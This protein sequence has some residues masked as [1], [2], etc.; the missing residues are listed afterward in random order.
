MSNKAELLGGIGILVD[1]TIVRQVPTCLA[2]IQSVLP[3][4]WDILGYLMASTWL[5]IALAVTPGP[6]IIV[7]AN[8]I[9][10]AVDGFICHRQLRTHTTVAVLYLTCLSRGFHLAGTSQPLTKFPELLL[11][12]VVLH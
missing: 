7:F 12:P 9:E 10:R 8:R 5:A 1:L 11:P 6:S 4:Q 3:E 2:Q